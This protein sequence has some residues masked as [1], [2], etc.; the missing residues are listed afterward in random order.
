VRSR[1]PPIGLFLHQFAIDR[2]FAI[3]ADSRGDVIVTKVIAT[4]N[5][6]GDGKLEVVVG[7]MSY[8]GEAIFV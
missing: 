4:L 6:D 1:S 3:G 7:S 8:E 2:G 5:L